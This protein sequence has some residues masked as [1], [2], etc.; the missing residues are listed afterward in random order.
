MNRFQ[1]TVVVLFVL[2]LGLSSVAFVF[3]ECGWRGFLFGNGAVYAAAS[4]AC[5]VN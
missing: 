1:I 3:K 2:L 5:K 4:G